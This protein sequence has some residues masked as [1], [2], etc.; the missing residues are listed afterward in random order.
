MRPNTMTTTEYSH[1][2]QVAIELQKLSNL[3]GE[4]ELKLSGLIRTTGHPIREEKEALQTIYAHG[5]DIQRAYRIV[6][7]RLDRGALA[8]AQ[9]SE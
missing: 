9:E 5:A 2:T 1:D 8:L 7:M 3:I 6:S 4:M